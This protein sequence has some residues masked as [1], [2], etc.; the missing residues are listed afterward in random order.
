MDGLLL[1]LVNFDGCAVVTAAS[2]LCRELLVAAVVVVV[3][4]VDVVVLVD[5]E[6][7]AGCGVS[8]LTI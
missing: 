2:G 3:V 1:L 4:D 7:A 8:T 5:V 6:L